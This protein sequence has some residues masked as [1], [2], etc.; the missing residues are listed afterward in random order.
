MAFDR[1]VDGIETATA[2]EGGLKRGRRVGGKGRLPLRPSTAVPR[3]PR[4]SSPGH[5]EAVLLRFNRARLL[6]DAPRADDAPTAVGGQAE[7]LPMDSARQVG[8]ADGF[9]Q[10]QTKSLAMPLCI[11]SNPLNPRLGEMK[12]R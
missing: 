10:S 8:R 3:P 4:F 7:R 5:S 1:P 12:C 9:Q 11:L 6:R 2:A